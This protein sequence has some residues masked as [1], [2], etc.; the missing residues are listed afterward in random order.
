M[1]FDRA[2]AADDPDWPRASDWLATG[3]SRAP[4]L[5]VVG[6][7]TS[8]GSIS[9]SEA[10][11]TP[12]EVREALRRLSP[13]D[14]AGHVDLA[15]LAVRDGG[16]WPVADLDLDLMVTTV[17]AR[18][19]ALDPR[20]VHAFLGG[21]NAITRPLVSG[22]CGPDLGR[23]G[24]VTFDAHHDVRTLTHGPRNGTP[25][26]GLIEDGLPGRN[27]AQIGIGAFT[28]SHT[29]R[30][31]CDEQE[32][33]VVLA[34]EV[35]R[36]GMD[37]ALARAIEPLAHCEVLY[38]DVDV[39]VLDAA[40]APAC[41]GARPGGLNPSQLFAGVRRLGADPRTV[42]ADFVEVDAGADTDGRTVM[43]TAMA[44]LAF[45]AGIATRGGA[46]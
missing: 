39:D 30:R 5:E 18:A 16:D 11:R 12:P 45:A 31:W 15:G 36:D 1:P 40:Y 19:A 9:A 21:D 2:P 10:W 7:P 20:P 27:V 37:A 22:R 26:R 43:V 29:Y 14:P 13:F 8:I 25:V 33:T 24:V 42:A 17:A 3:T 38:V 46:A 4:G 34:D 6:V 28:N 41:P 32:V 35:H 44:L 23:V